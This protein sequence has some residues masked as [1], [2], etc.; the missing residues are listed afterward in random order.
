M[1]WNKTNSLSFC[2]VAIIVDLRDDA[3]SELDRTLSQCETTK[4]CRDAEDPEGEC[5]DDSDSNFTGNKTDVG[6]Y[7]MFSIERFL[8]ER[9]LRDYLMGFVGF[10]ADCLFLPLP[11][12]RSTNLRVSFVSTEQDV[13][14]TK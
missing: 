11:L 7:I 12:T 2:S 3:A 13:A 1:I 4:K 14:T 10:V 6:K 5:N 8:I 9:F